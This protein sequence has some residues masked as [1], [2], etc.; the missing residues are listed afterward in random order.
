MRQY[1]EW[2]ENYLKEENYDV[3]CKCVEATKKMNSEFPELIKVRGHVFCWEGGKYEK[4]PHCWLETQHG[5]IID[6]TRTQYDY[7]IHHYEAWDES[8]GEPTGKC[9]N[10]GEY[11]FNNRYLC[12]EKCDAE[13]LAYVNGCR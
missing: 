5:H 7:L 13:Y 2:I 1:F 3:L 10:C 4:Y 12:S 8:K 9:P 11:C 6:P